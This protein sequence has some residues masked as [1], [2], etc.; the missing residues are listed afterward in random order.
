MSTWDV[1]G[2]CWGAP[3]TVPRCAICKAI[4]QEPR[5]A[6]RC[7]HVQHDPQLCVVL[8]KVPVTNGVRHGRVGTC[9]VSCTA[10][11]NA[12]ERIGKGAKP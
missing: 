3:P 1:H 4:A 2:A 5:I 8:D 9:L 7:L 10:P 12:R 6:M 11:L